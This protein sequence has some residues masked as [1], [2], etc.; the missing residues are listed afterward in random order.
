MSGHIGMMDTILERQDG[1]GPKRGF[2]KKPR[3]L[4]I[5]RIQTLTVSL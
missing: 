2:K 1:G 5:N 3:M 4:N